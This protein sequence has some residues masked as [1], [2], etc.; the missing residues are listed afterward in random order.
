MLGIQVLY[1]HY[2]S[3]TYFKACCVSLTESEMHS[4]E[5]KANFKVRGVSQK[6]LVLAFR[7]FG[8][9]CGGYR[10]PRFALIY[11]PLSQGAG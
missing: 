1:D 2:Y 11:L 4:F 10:L 7:G 8:T 9:W 5:N 3:W 6:T